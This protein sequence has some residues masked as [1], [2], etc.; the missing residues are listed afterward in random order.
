MV[1]GIF[2]EESNRRFIAIIEVNGKL[3]E[4]YMASSSKLNKLYNLQD[5]EVFLEKNIGKNTRTKYVVQALKDNNDYIWLN[6]KELN[7]LYYKQILENNLSIISEKKINNNLRID[8]FDKAQKELIEV[9]GILSQNSSATFPSFETERFYRQL[10][11]IYEWKNKKRLVIILMNPNIKEIKL[12]KE[13]I[14]IYDQL[15]KCIKNNLKIE[16]Y[17]MVFDKEFKLEKVRYVMKNGI[18]KIE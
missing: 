8:F 16:I 15:I 1:R 13:Y 3:E 12:N 2:K 14:E 9:K 6:L 10:K 5:K 4:C 7:K 11:E 18:M 17:K